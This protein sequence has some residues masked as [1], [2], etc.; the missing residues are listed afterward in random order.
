MGSI[1]RLRFFSFMYLLRFDKIWIK[2]W[3]RSYNSGFFFILLS[4]VELYF[5]FYIHFLFV[6][7][8]PSDLTALSLLEDFTFSLFCC[9]FLKLLSLFWFLN[10]LLKEFTPNWNYIQ[11]VFFS[12]TILTTIGENKKNYGKCITIHKRWSTPQHWQ[13]LEKKSRCLNASLGLR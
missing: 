12:T 8:S 1:L 5:D 2:V 10:S 11:S 7:S 9:V 3:D 13:F 6:I 4:C